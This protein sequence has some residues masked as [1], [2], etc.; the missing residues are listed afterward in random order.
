LP[1]HCAYCGLSLEDFIHF[2]KFGCE[3]CLNFLEKHPLV[4]QKVI[5]K[6]PHA[7]TH[8]LTVPKFPQK[9]NF[10]KKNPR[11]IRW[12]IRYRIARN[13]KKNIFP[14]MNA[15]NDKMIN[16]I[17][18]KF[19]N[20]NEFHPWKDPQESKISKR[21]TLRAN[22]ITQDDLIVNF[23]LGDEDGIRCEF[24]ING[25]GL[26]DHKIGLPE[27]AGKYEILAFLSQRSLF[28]YT[29]GWGFLNSC[30]T[31]SM[32][33]DRVSIQMEI[34]MNRSNEI[35]SDVR[36]SFQWNWEENSISFAVNSSYEGVG[37]SVFSVKNFTKRRK[38]HFLSLLNSIVF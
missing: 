21:K 13:L 4:F 8:F 12:T 28:S 37:K 36:N 11:N 10:F 24:L 9:V 19:P 14:I 38:N 31:N 33:G 5:A 34:P 35:Q 27:F 30:P 7:S 25:E 15:D 6:I 32:R 16:L 29:K 23:L 3:F 18:K 1:K 22:F 26:P 17:Q 20:L 2:G